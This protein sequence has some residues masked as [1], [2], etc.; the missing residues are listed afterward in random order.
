MQ[1][2]STSKPELILLGEDL[3]CGAYVL[4][5]H[6][7][8]ALHIR[9]G[10]FKGGKVVGVSAG[11]YAYVGSAIGRKGS[12]T[13]AA[14]LIRHAT[15]S[16]GSLPH[17][18]RKEIIR[19]LGGKTP[20]AKTLFWNID[21]LLDEQAATIVQVYVLRSMKHLEVAVAQTMMQDAVV[22]ESGLGANDA[23]GQT[24]LLRIEYGDVWWDSLRERLLLID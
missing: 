23:P 1:L 18:I 5:I 15:R 19:Q 13:L 22:F 8:K 3:P 20:K 4:R 9:F 7:E 17:S 2:A 24:H 21:Y 10:R 12:T 6:V 11:E 16:D 14:R